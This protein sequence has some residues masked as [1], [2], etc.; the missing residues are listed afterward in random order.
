MDRSDMVAASQPEAVR[1]ALAAGAEELGHAGH[2]H[3]GA[4]L[5][6]LRE[7]EY[8]GRHIRVRTTYEITVDGR[9]F[10]VH[11]TVDN[12]GRVH[13]HGLPTRDFASVIGLVQRVIDQFPDDFPVEPTPSADPGHSHHHGGGD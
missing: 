9:E 13:Y 3:G 1:T 10:A 8:Q 5:S 6:S 2:A 12:N 4:D 7:A 11:L